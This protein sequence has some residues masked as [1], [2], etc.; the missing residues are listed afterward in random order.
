MNNGKIIIHVGLQKTAS[1]FLQNVVFPRLENV[2]YIGRPFT[3]ENYAFNS[4]QCADNSL[5]D[6]SV[7]GRE[8]DRIKK[9][10]SE[11]G[12]ILIS[13][14]LFSGYPFYNYINRGVIA[15]RIRNVV[16]EAEIVL[17]LR[18]QIE[19]IMALYNQYVKIGWL[20]NHLDESILYKPGAGFSLEQWLM[21]KRD[22][23]ARN[24]FINH[25]SMFNAEHFRYSQ[26][27][28]LYNDLFRSVHI[29]LYEDFRDNPKAF[30]ERLAS[31]LSSQLPSDLEVPKEA[32][33]KMIVNK[34]LTKNQLHTKLIQ[35]RL[36]RISPRA[37]SKSGRVLAKILSRIIPDN[38]ENNKG[39]V[40]S[41]LK[42]GGIF[43]DNYTLN[44]RLGLGMQK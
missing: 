12:T 15:E 17:I 41:I 28:L 20:D 32:L 18:G 23:D 34:S 22:W 21:G 13:D 31:I 8:I 19:L 7:V 35:N 5:Y 6:P 26:L 2:M 29:F 27:Y 10:R 4:L 44:E 42:E 40:I 16:P 24:R 11:G 14:E 36:S 1:Q 39:H 43:G 25:R 30:L 38:E 3:Q 9:E 33:Q 37:N